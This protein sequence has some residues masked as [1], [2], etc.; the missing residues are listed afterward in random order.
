MCLKVVVCAVAVGAEA[1]A[2]KNGVEVAG[3]VPM[4][5]AF[6]GTLLSVFAFR[7]RLASAG[8]WCNYR[9]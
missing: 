6:A 7:R 5:L 3:E 4:A 8:L 9:W 2:D 1:T